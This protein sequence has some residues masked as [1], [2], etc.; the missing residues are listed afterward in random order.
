MNYFDTRVTN[1]NSKSQQHKT[2]EKIYR[3]HELEKKRDYNERVQNIE[4]GTFTPLIYSIKG[5]LGPECETFYKHLA[6]K[7]AMK[8]NQQYEK[9]I[10]GIR[11]KL[12]FI[13]M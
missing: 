9:V 7:I 1:T 5:G 2:L 10:T 11:C 13:I 3:T 8:T 12:S 6:D 4:F